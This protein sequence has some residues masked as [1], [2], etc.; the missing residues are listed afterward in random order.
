MKWCVYCKKFKFLSESKNFSLVTGATI[1]PSITN[2]HNNNLCKQ[3]YIIF[4]S[5]KATKKLLSFLGKTQN[6]TKTNTDVNNFF[7]TVFKVIFLLRYHNI[8]NPKQL[9][10]L[11]CISSLKNFVV[12]MIQKFK[13]KI[14]SYKS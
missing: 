8:S 10:F 12:M 4:S 2:H 7:A 1:S 3:N 6:N 11:F 13:S 14:I 9:S 5:C